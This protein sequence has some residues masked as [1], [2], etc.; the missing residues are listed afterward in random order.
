MHD[1][2]DG[3]HLQP[4]RAGC[5][6]REDYKHEARRRALAVTWA[7]FPID[8]FPRPLRRPL[9]LAVEGVLAGGSMSCDRARVNALVARYWPTRLPVDLALLF[10]RLDDAASYSGEALSR[11]ADHTV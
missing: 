2:R 4:A 9:Q 7:R 10:K 1:D 3:E 8:E 11:N 6:V 5:T